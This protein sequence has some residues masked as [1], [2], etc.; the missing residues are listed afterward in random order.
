MVTPATGSTDEYDVDWLMVPSPTSPRQR[1]EPGQGATEADPFLTS[2]PNPHPS[3]PT[4]VNRNSASSRGTGFSSTS[5]GT[6][7]S[8]YGDVLAHPSLSFTPQEDGANPFDAPPGQLQPIVPAE[9]NAITSR[10]IL[11]PSQLAV[12]T[13][14]EVLPRG[15]EDSEPELGDEVGQVVIAR[16]VAVSPR[17]ATAELTDSGVK[18]KERRRSWIP[19]F[20]WNRD[21]RTR[22]AEEGGL[23]LFDAGRHSPSN[24]LSPLSSPSPI[25]APP[26]LVTVPKNEMREFG[27]RSVLPLL[28]GAVIPRPLA[29]SAAASRPV[30]GLSGMSSDGTTGSAKSGGTVYTDA[31]ETLSSRDRSIRSPSTPAAENLDPLDVP[32]PPALA[33][34]TSSSQ[35]SLSSS[36]D[37]TSDPASS[38]TER[39]SHTTMATTPAT[40]NSPMR[41]RAYAH[42]PPG[43]EDHGSIS[44]WDKF[45]HGFSRPPSHDQLGTFGSSNLTVVP[46]PASAFGGGVRLVHPTLDDAPPGANG[47]WRQ[48]GGVQSN[49]GPGHRFTFGESRVAKYHDTQGPPSEHGSFHSRLNLSL[50]SGSSVVGLSDTLPARSR[51][52]QRSDSVQGS[53]SP[54][55][56]AFGSRSR[57]RDPQDS[58]PRSRSPGS[59][60][61]VPWV[62]GLDSDWR[63]A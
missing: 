57:S 63:P 17:A 34:F 50:S 15:S 23:L 52:L 2:L 59:S 31:L 22:D 45:E 24:S 32:A 58:L 38:L 36:S 1:T 16:R 54:P 43:L 39:Q 60:L 14:E 11:S 35:H 46:L 62:G 13:E 4:D 53:L 27:S 25:G 30:S 28:G 18:G 47:S 41:Q 8:G 7:I 12:L 33:E 48:L 3:P 10:R 19:R 9:T 55:L 29:G 40:G 37:P 49:A 5:S 26:K 56:S 42:G 44:S 21:E 20:S 51:A 6:N 61:L